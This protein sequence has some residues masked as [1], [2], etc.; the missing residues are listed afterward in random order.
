M[1]QR[2]MQQEDRRMA[3]YGGLVAQHQ[4]ES[5][6]A[7]ASVQRALESVRCMPALQAVSCC[8]TCV[9]SASHYWSVVNPG[10]HPLHAFADAAAVSWHVWNSCRM[11]YSCR[12]ERQRRRLQA[13]F[14]ACRLKSRH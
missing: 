5:K 7:V 2:V 14:R 13:S 6:E 9:H 3:T 4:D 11:L 1:L 8:G 12:S 10:I